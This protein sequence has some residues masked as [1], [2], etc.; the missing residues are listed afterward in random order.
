MIPLDSSIHRKITGW[1]NSKQPESRGMLV[2]DWQAQ[3]DW[4]TQ[5]A[6]AIKKLYEYGGKLPESWRN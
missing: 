4:D 1:Y 2:R 3:Y 6:Y 5:R